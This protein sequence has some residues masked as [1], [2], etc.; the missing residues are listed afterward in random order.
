MT[1]RTKTVEYSFGTLIATTTDSA[2]NSLGTITAA[3]Q[4]TASRTIL[5]AWVE[6]EGPNA[7][8][9]AINTFTQ[10]N[11]RLTLGAATASVASYA[12]SFT[13]G[14]YGAYVFSLPFDFTAYFQASFGAG[15]S[16]TVKLEIDSIETGGSTKGIVYPSAKLY[17]TYQYDDAAETVLT[18]TVRIPI[19]TAPATLSSNGATVA[20]IPA[21][22][23]F[24]PEGGKTL[25]QAFLE[26]E[27]HDARSGTTDSQPF[28]T[29]GAA[30]ENAFGYCYGAY[31]TPRTLRSTI[32]WPAASLSASTTAV[33]MRASS[34]ASL[35]ASVVLVVTYTYTLAS[36]TRVLNSLMLVQ[37]DQDYSAPSASATETDTT[38]YKERVEF[39]FHI[40]E[41]GTLTLVNSGL[42]LWA[43][44]SPESGNSY[45]AWQPG[46]ASSVTCPPGLK[47][48]AYNSKNTGP[49]SATARFDGGVGTAAF[50]PA[51]G[52]NTLAVN[53]WTYRYDASLFVGSLQFIAYINYTSDVSSQ[54]PD[55][56]NHTVLYP[57]VPLTFQACPASGSVNP[58]SNVAPFDG[59]TLPSLAEAHYYASNFH[60]RGSVYSVGIAG[61]QNTNTISAGIKRSAAN[62]GQ[63]RSRMMQH[64]PGATLQNMWFAINVTDLFV[65]NP[66]CVGDTRVAPAESGMK[67]RLHGPTTDKAHAWAV[68]GMTYHSI[69]YSVAGSV[70]GYTGDGSGIAVRLHDAATGQALQATTTAVGGS[71]SFTHYDGTS[72]V[73]TTASQDSTH[74]GRS[75]DGLAT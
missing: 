39:K 31:S 6:V 5:A 64:P 34:G 75:A 9:T 30:A 44:V 68:F 32:A 19:Q 7:G 56:H 72:N 25:C 60:M 70:S 65:Q 29:I 4:E 14:S 45:F 12:N 67:F 26:V 38:N 22:S 36:T 50:T 46:A 20:T 43:P 27:W 41:P 61:A 21:L 10:F 40:A 49:M 3:L 69:G 55:A 58:V 15:T 73:F 66:G 42:K 28:C 47:S 71:Y 51:R 13:P 24:L 62:G 2:Y 37:H 52:F 17:I 16:Q 59:A 8:N 33:A 48:G 35:R 18:K 1:M 11:A 23:T 53:H 57:A 74:L 54:G 63:Y